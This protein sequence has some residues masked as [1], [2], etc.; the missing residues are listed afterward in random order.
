MNRIFGSDRVVVS[1]E[2]G[3]TRDAIDVEVQNEGRSY[4]FVDTAG[5]RKPGRRSRLAE[6]GSALMSLRALER[7]EIA[8]VILD[9]A[10]GIPAQEARVIGLAQERG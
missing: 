5:I 3:T 10:T 1:N 6:R 8:L 4:L 9:A 7:A 2:P